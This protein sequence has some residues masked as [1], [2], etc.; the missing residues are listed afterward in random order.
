[1]RCDECD[2]F[3]EGYPI[4]VVDIPPINFM[5]EEVFHFEDGFK[6]TW[7]GNESLRIEDLSKGNCRC[8]G[9]SL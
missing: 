8:R 2:N 1:M 3:Q 6:C 9:D 7:N 4:K 5:S